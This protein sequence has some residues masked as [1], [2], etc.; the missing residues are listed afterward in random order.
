MIHP[1]RLWRNWRSRSQLLMRRPHPRGW[2]YSRRLR[3]SELSENG[4]EIPAYDELAEVWNEYA[5]VIAPYYAPYLRHLAA[6]RG[7]ELNAVLDLACGAG[8]HT[9]QLAEFVSEVVGVDASEPMLAQARMYCHWWSNVQFVRGDFCEFRL[10]RQFDAAICA[11]NSLNYVN[12]VAELE[13]VFRNVA[14]HLRPGGVFLFDTITDFGMRRLRG[15]YLHVEAS[16]KRF[17]LGFRYDSQRREEQ[18]VVM[19]PSGVEKHVRGPIDP[20][21]VKRAARNSGLDVDDY[22]S[23]ALLPGWL[24]TGTACFFVLKKRA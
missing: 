21:D 6:S 19:L 24:F 9:E 16:G 22:F 3:F 18:A 13:M 17:A 7:L 5:R 2:F 4:P 20:S 12:G 8:F 23:D 10:G 15:S 11:F 14:E 1:I